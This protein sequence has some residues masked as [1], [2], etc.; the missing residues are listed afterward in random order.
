MKK[1]ICGLLIL[2]S[3]FFNLSFAATF[4][5]INYEIP[6]NHYISTNDGNLLQLTSNDISSDDNI[7]ININPSD[8]YLGYVELTDNVL[9]QYKADMQESFVDGVKDL[10]NSTIANS[11]GVSEF[12]YSSEIIAYKN[13]MRMLSCEPVEITK[14][15]A[16]AVKYIIYSEIF[17]Y[18]LVQTGYC[19][20]N[21]NNYYYITFTGDYTD[22]EINSF[23]NSIYINDFIEKSDFWENIKKAVVVSLILVIGQAIKETYKKIKAPKQKTVIPLDDYIYDPSLSDI[24]N[25]KKKFSEMNIITLDDLIKNK[26]DE[27]TEETYALALEQYKLRFEELPKTSRVDELKLEI[28]QLDEALLN[29]NNMLSQAKKDLGNLT[30]EDAENMYRQKLISEAQKNEMINSIE[31][32]Q[33][34]IDLTPKNIAETQKLKSELEQELKKIL[35]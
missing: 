27:Y 4:N 28:S 12:E 22:S 14:N 9:N 13:S 20:P 29:L 10:P 21:G 35:N 3:I 6:K 25:Q 17:N 26:K 15:K 2:V 31:V 5:N 1:I 19:V 24:E 34:T 32:L 23:L 30:I 16:Q 33:T 8:S 7:V 11:W 18:P